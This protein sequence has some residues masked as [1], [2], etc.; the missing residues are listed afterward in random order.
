[1]MTRWPTTLDREGAI[2]VRQITTI[3]LAMAGLALFDSA[4][5]DWAGYSTFSISLLW[6]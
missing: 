5:L 4:A 6:R 2:G 1:M 3:V